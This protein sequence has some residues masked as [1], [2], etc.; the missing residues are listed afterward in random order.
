M[1][2]S[3]FL[4]V[5]RARF[6]IILFTFLVTVATAAAISLILPKSY[7]ATTSLVLNFKG[8]D[9]V[10]GAAIPAQLMPGYMATQVD[11]ITSLNVAGKVVDKLKFAES[12]AAR[13]QFNQATKGRGNIRDWFADALLKKLDVEPSRESS[14]I[15][16]SFSGA[17]PTF[18][19]TVANAFAEAYQQTNIQLKVGPSLSAAGYLG[20]QTKALRDHLEEVQ[21][22]LS[23]YQQDNGLTSAFEQF[24]VES[25][26][27]N[28][29]S[30]QLVMAQSQAIEASSR[31]AGTLGNAEDS[32]DIAASNLV[33]GLKAD[34]ARA[35]SKLAE[36][37][38]RV[39][40]NHPQYQSAKA[41]ADKI[42]SQLEEEVKRATASVGGSAKIYRQREAEL[43]AA[44]ASQKTKVLKLNHARDQMMILQKD[45]E[46]AQRSLDAVNQ[47]FTQTNLEG[48]ANQSEVAVLNPATPPLE[49]SS[50]K[51][52]LNIIL[53]MF[54]GGLLG[55]G[56]GLIAEMM[57]KRVRSREDITE[58][59]D[60][61][62][63]AIIKEKSSKKRR[64]RLFG[65]ARQLQPSV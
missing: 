57:D 52:M 12:S 28:E 23:A 10:S 50:P 16:I 27:L 5:L 6:K 21:T 36:L 26:K 32:P 19:A 56:F 9:P 13:V 7:K 44:V 38:Q 11:I 40:H 63:L 29:L 49:A 48:Q 24:D 31:H 39:D 30:A 61:P 45:V 58:A 59:F 1:N 41:E 37:S 55:I 3:Q 53:S 33:Q 54:L 25:S 34:L 51:V 64:F 18:A 15:S 8:A 2:F 17:D 20:T 14:V 62:V 43:R 46:S 42:K 35:E 22:K 65:S 4:L 47:R 60:I